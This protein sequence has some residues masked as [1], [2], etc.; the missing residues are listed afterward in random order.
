MNNSSNYKNFIEKPMLSKSDSSFKVS[1]ASKLNENSKNKS[2][3]DT[4]GEQILQLSA[5]EISF[6]NTEPNELYEISINVRNVSQFSQKIKVKRPQCAALAVTASREGNLAAG[7][8][9]KLTVVFDSKEN[10]RISDRVVVATENL[11]IEIPVNVYP[12]IGKLE[13]EPFLNFGFVRVGTEVQSLWHIT[14]KAEN[15]VSIKLTPLLADQSAKLELSNSELTLQGGEKKAVKLTLCSKTA[16]TV[17]GSIEIEPK[18]INYSTLEF[19]ANFC[20]YSRM[21][22]D[23]EGKEIKVVQID[24]LFGGETMQTSAFLVNNSP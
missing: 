20:E 9:L 6:V 2:I 5:P 13:F 4:L 23:A 15:Q 17:E 24:P 1:A 16:G 19:V 14:N 10:V 11:E 18:S 12:N 21:L 22:S 8:D 7:L 3:V